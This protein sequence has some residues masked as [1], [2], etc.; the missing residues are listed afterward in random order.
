MS[1]LA[2][3]D[4]DEV[5]EGDADEEWETWRR[6]KTPGL[7]KNYSSLQAAFARVTVSV[8]ADKRPVSR[9]ATQNATYEMRPQSRNA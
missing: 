6:G 7:E 8:L 1:L 2:F 5:Q 9:P 4:P 3:S